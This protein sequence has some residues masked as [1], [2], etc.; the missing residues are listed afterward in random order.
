[1]TA[2]VNE[3]N[4]ETFLNNKC[5]VLDFWAAWCAPCRSVSPLLEK[6]AEE[7]ES[8]AVVGKINIDENPGL[9]A[10]FGID[11]IP[12][13]ILLKNKTEAGRIVGVHT[14]EEYCGEIDK[15]L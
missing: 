15:M 7:Y 9:A 10:K 3:K 1:M 2:E 11:A 13:V 14:F 12:T 8:D 4:F 6:I 5:V